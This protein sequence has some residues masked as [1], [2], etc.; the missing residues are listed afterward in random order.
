MC[1]YMYICMYVY[2]CMKQRDLNR[3]EKWTEN[4]RDKERERKLD[5][6]IK[7][8]MITGKENG[9]TDVQWMW[10]KYMIYLKDITL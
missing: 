5:E 7:R 1:M 6:G 3:E 4:E 9:N 10:S 8:K 2:T